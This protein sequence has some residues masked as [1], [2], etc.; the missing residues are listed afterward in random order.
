MREEGGGN[1]SIQPVARAK[2]P[3]QL[4]EFTQFSGTDEPPPDKCVAV[5][6]TE[7]AVGDAW[8][9]TWAMSPHKVVG[10]ATAHVCEA[11]VLGGSLA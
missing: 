1:T 6:S 7:Q 2:C 11:G 3:S 8:A 4:I 5:P 9:S 10:G